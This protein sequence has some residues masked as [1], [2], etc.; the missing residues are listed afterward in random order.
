MEN[1]SALKKILPYATFYVY[2]NIMLHTL[3]THSF[4]YKTKNKYTKRNETETVELLL[5]S[6]G[7]V[8]I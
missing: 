2:Q 4:Y 8:I 7:T 6:I 5:C 1:H 3:N